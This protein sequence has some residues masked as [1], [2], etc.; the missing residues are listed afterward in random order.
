MKRRL[1]LFFALFGAAFIGCASPSADDDSAN[2]EAAQ[3]ARPATGAVLESSPVYAETKGLVPTDPAAARAWAI[4]QLSPLT[5]CDVTLF[6]D[7]ADPE[8]ETDLSNL[9]AWAGGA[10]AKKPKVKISYQEARVLGGAYLAFQD[11][12]PKK[13]QKVKG[14]WVQTLIDRGLDDTQRLT[15]IA[16]TPGG[17][18][19]SPA[20]IAEC[21]TFVDSIRQATWGC[22]Q[23]LV[24]DYLAVQAGRDKLADA[25]GDLA[26]LPFYSWIQ[27]G[28]AGSRN[29]QSTVSNRTMKALSGYLPKV[30]KQQ[31]LQELAAEA[32]AY[33]ETHEHDDPRSKAMGTGPANWRGYWELDRNGQA[34][35][36]CG[37]DDAKSELK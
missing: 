8:L 23:Q 37:F 7:V 27:A 1:G 5:P 4:M 11:P 33:F 12:D 20:S 17:A 2:A 31:E 9:S 30:G 16:K 28:P 25:P 26:K 29:V 3:R 15:T 19:L 6:A 22:L 13:V 10:P 24:A 36:Y 34:Q 35:P 21:N 18:N 32:V 14:T